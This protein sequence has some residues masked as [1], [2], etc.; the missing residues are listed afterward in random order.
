MGDLSKKPIA[1]ESRTGLHR[2]TTCG[3]ALAQGLFLPGL[4]DASSGEPHFGHPPAGV[5]FLASQSTVSS[6]NGGAW[7][8]L[9]RRQ[10]NGFPGL[11]TSWLLFRGRRV[12]F[13]FLIKYAQVVY[14]VSGPAGVIE[15]VSRDSRSC[16][17]HPD[18]N[19]SEGFFVLFLGSNMISGAQCLKT[20]GWGR[21]PPSSQ[22]KQ[23]SWL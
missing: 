19:S 16:P 20:Q 6:A 21:K 23:E 18:L 14:W 2:Q 4:Q 17:G 3:R 12:L 1:A 5:A 7:R 9:R 15:W 11:G 10:R 8:S 22:A 13:F